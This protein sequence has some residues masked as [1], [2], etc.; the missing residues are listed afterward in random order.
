MATN[1]RPSEESDTPVRAFRL[2]VAG[3]APN[4]VLALRNLKALCHDCYG[5]N[6]SIEV[7]DV[8]LSHE[9]AWA[10]GVIATPMTIR[11]FPLP[12]VQII[13]NLSNS[14]QVLSVLQLDGGERGK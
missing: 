12:A 13:G 1:T 7:V 10:D 11:L 6:F 8:L 14:D 4:S 2:Y 3:E 5:D 9:R